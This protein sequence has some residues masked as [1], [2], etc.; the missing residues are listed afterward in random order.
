[1]PQ[2]LISQKN[3]PLKGVLTPPGDKS[4]SH[5]AIMLGGIAE[6]T[7]TVRGLLEGED[8]LRTVDALKAVGADITK[9][10][11]GTWTIKGVGLNGM[12]TPAHVLDMGNSGTAARLLI[13][14]LAGKN[15][16]SSFT[17]DA[18][19][20]KR[21]MGRVVTPL[22]QMGASFKSTD[23][24]LPLSV[25]G[26]AS[27]KAIAYKLPV[28][29]AQVKSA[30][31][32]AGLS[33]DGVTKVIETILTRDH[34][35]NMLRCFGAQL[36]VAAE[37]DAEVISLTGKPRL[38]GQN[39]VVPADP[40]S[41]AF[42]AVAAILHEGSKVTLK[43]VGLNPRRAG[44]FE[45]LLEMG[46][47][48]TFADQRVEGGE[49]VADLIIEGSALHGITVPPERAPSMIDEYPI[50]SVAAA[51]A[52]G[53]TRMEGLGELRVKESD[54]LA[55]MA[56]GLAKCGVKVE[57]EGDDLIVHG[58]GKPPKGGATIETAMDHRIA[59]SFLV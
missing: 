10:A 9:S 40:S 51:C 18:S 27:P 59:M 41:A 57:I 28:A 50:L 33:A 3:G 53:T 4:I 8:V 20:C 19:L 34:S 48:I 15:F 56:Q 29:S 31:L 2:P 26:A 32:L 43:G 1:M 38:K 11:D 22:E 42:P 47:K 21:P 55:L 13:G 46:A 23:G 25:T 6:G 36:T 37:G 30:V 7:T 49:P 16:T 17:G 5:R 54:R 58:N 35:E 39:I 52:N 24:K 44:L 12:K 14:L 45:T